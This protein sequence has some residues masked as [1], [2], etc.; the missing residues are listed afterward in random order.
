MFMFM[1]MFGQHSA[2][3]E[4]CSLGVWYVCR[5]GGYFLG[6]GGLCCWFHGSSYLLMAASVFLEDGGEEFQFLCRG[7]LVTDTFCSVYQGEED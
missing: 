1:I 7:I 5:G 4:V 3:S 2:E 6:L